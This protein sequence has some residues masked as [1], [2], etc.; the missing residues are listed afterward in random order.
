M[1]WNFHPIFIIVIEIISVLLTVILINNFI[2]G[3]KMNKS[4]FVSFFSLKHLCVREQEMEN[5]EW[6]WSGAV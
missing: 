4:E 5:P 1:L 3:F 6:N 2:V